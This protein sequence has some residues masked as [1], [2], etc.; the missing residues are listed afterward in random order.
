MGCASRPLYYLAIPPDFFAAVA[1]LELHVLHMVGDEMTPYER[2]LGDA[3][4][5][6]AMLFVREGA[7]EAAWRVVD[8]VLEN[9]TPV[10]EY[11][12][13]KWR[14]PEADRIVAEDGGWYNPEPA[15]P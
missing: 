6:D 9:K 8:P 7:V 11:E 5:G 2:L 1:G 10:H 4:R 14:P 3:V 12:P 13:R 15:E